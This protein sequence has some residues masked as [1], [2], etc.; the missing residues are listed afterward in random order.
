MN[1]IV[2]DNYPAKRLPDDLRGNIEEGREVRVTVEEIDRAVA[3]ATL[4]S[5]FARRAPPYRSRDDIDRGL[6]Q[7]RAEWGDRG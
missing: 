3:A 1:K 5:I 4:D 2:R 6:E 7:L